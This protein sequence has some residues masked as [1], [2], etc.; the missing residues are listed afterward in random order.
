MSAKQIPGLHDLVG[1]SWQYD[2]SKIEIQ[3]YKELQSGLFC[4]FTDKRI[5]SMQVDEIE[6]FFSAIGAFEALKVYQAYKYKPTAKLRI[7]KPIAVK[8]MSFHDDIEARLQELILE[9]SSTEYRLNCTGHE[10]KLYII[11]SKVLLNAKTLKEILQLL[12]NEIEG[13]RIVNKRCEK[14]KNQK[15]FTYGK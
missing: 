7:K 4:I 6:G 13:K 1:K 10:W 15:P 9:T 2:N 12:I 5:L 8:P 3:R 11:R 14:F